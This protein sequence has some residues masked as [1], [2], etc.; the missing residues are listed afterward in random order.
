MKK[1]IFLAIVSIFPSTHAIANNDSGWWRDAN[2]YYL[3]WA[4]SEDSIFQASISRIGLTTKSPYVGFRLVGSHERFCQNKGDSFKG[5]VIINVNDQPINFETSCYKNK[6][7]NMYP[8]KNMS[9]KFILDE[10]NSYRNKE[11]TFVISYNDAPDWV[12]TIP[13]KNFGSYYSSLTKSL[14]EVL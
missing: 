1:Y 11:L 10:L 9:N 14:K 8:S 2:D 12:F 7:L 13:T 5:T 3:I 6:Y 4:D